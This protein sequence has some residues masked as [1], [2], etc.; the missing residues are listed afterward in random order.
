MQQ[1]FA[2]GHRLRRSAREIGCFGQSERGAHIQPLIRE[3]AGGVR[4]IEAVE[5]HERNLEQV[6]ARRAGAANRRLHPGMIELSAENEGVNADLH[7]C[8]FAHRAPV[9]PW[10]RCYYRFWIF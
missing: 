3:D 5:V 1:L 8:S 10:Q 7:V 9:H 6:E 4:R 2:G